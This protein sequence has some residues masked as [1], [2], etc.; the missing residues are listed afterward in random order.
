VQEEEEAGGAVKERGKA[1]QVRS[2]AHHPALP[3]SRACSRMPSPRRT[4]GTVVAVTPLEVQVKLDSG[5]YGRLHAT[6]LPLT[7]TPAAPPAR[8][9]KAAAAAASVPSPLAGYAA[10]A[11]VRVRIC[12]HARGDPAPDGKS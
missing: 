6:S 4:Q 3:L 2:A 5:R 11:A 10:G 8:G 9:R 12:G 7:P 1:M